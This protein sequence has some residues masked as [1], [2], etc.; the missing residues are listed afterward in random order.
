MQEI[1]EAIYEDGT[2]KPLDQLDLP[3]HKK[4][5]IKLILP[6]TKIPKP[7]QDMVDIL[8]GPLPVRSVQDMAKDSEIQID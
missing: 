7:V 2:L 4:V 5:K 6:K 1:I 8:H 3:E